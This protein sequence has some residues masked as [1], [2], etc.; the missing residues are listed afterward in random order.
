ML[1]AIL[2]DKQKLSS[3]T[4]KSLFDKDQ[5]I[6]IKLYPGERLIKI[7]VIEYESK[8]TRKN[9]NSSLKSKGNR[10]P[11]QL[12]LTRRNS[13]GKETLTREKKGNISKGK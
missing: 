6:G 10:T 12:P 3:L 13:K 11:R 5:I 9:N 7:K 4:T 8:D 2:K 1:Y